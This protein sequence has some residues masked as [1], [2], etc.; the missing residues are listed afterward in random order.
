M[1]LSDGFNKVKVKVHA[2]PNWIHLRD[3]WPA[4]EEDEEGGGGGGG[5]GEGG[6]GGGG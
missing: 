2:S 6:G 1:D 5:E 4:M 3:I